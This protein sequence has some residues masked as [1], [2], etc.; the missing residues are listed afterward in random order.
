MSLKTSGMVLA[1]DASM[2]S[3]SMTDMLTAASDTG[4]SSRLADN[5]M[6]ISKNSSS[7]VLADRD[8][9]LINKRKLSG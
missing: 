1:P 3:R 6:G 2:V 7:S 9:E 8:A 5:T 4:C